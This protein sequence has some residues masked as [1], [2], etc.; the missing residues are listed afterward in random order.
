MVI[1]VL[2][3]GSIK[4]S[5]TLAAT[6]PSLGAAATYGILSSTYTNTSASTVN[7][8]VGFTTGPAVAPGG[9]HTN[10][11]SA[12]P[13]STA[14]ADQ[15]SA[16]TNLNNQ[17]CTVNFPAGAVVITGTYT[18]GVYCSTG[19]MNVSGTVTLNGSGTYIFRA[20]GALNTAAGTIVT[21]AGGASACDVFWTPVA[22]T[23]GANTTFVGTVIDDSAITAG[24][25]TNWV[26]RALSF[27]STVTTA[28]TT[29]TVPTCTAPALNVVKTVINDSGRNKVVSVFPLFVGGTPVTSGTTNTFAP[30]TYAVT[31]TTDPNYAQTFSGDC[32]ASGNV[33]LASGDNKFC[34]VTNDDVGAS[35]RIAPVPPLIELVKVPNPLNLPAGP[36]SVTY[37]Y[38][39]RN[40]GVVTATNITMVGDTCS[41]INL[42]S[43]DTNA[44]GQLEV[45]ETWTYTCTT[46]ISQTHTN[47][48]VTTGMAN[49]LTA[50]DIASATVVVGSSAVPPLIHLTKTPSSFTLPFGG[51][52][53]YTEKITNPGTTPLSNVLIT[54]DKCSPLTFTS[55]DTNSDALLDPTEIWT[56]T[57]S[58][59]LPK[60]TT[61]TAIASG[62]ASGLTARDF[63]IATVV[64]AD[65]LPAL[66]NTGSS[67]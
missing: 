5:A 44:N 55:G 35:A 67:P 23:L 19:A 42:I 38:T 60:T 41:P 20:A 34:I 37:T 40:I 53:T 4:P 3:I 62:Q 13:Y 32:D 21:L 27:A 6:T 48:V 52:V 56:Y 26:G 50:T 51:S 30:G 8:D 61:N 12:A 54:D 7:G 63:A 59:N 45:S 47:N 64:V 31:E 1:V 2:V 24:A 29:I 17:P 28:T 65:G 22:T 33:S 66:P 43:G 25:N 36:G 49:G 57:C 18:P 15:G 58:T 9:T 39:L 46:T 14:G 10:Y 16:L 11:G